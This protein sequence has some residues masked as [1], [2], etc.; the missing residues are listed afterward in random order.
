VFDETIITKWEQESVGLPNSTTK[1]EMTETMFAYC[2]S[3]LQHRAL[4][5][6]NSPNGAIRVFDGDVY[7][8]DT[9]VSDETKLAL[10]KAVRVLED[11]PDSQKDWH[12]DSDGKVLD[13][14]HPSLFPLVY[15]TSKVL[16]IGAPVTTL[17]DCIKKCGE[18]DYANT[19]SPVAGL[20]VWSDKFQWLPCEVDIM[21]GEKP[22]IL[23]YINNLHPERHRELYGLVEDVIHASIPLW[24]KTVIPTNDLW[25]TPQRIEYTSYT[26][27][28]DPE[29]WPEEDQIQR[30]EG[31]DEN[32]FWCRKQEWIEQTRVVE[33]PEPPEEFQPHVLK[34]NPLSFR[35]QFGA[36]PLQ[37]I[38]KLA[39]IE[40]TPEKPEYGGA[41]GTWHVEGKRVRS[42]LSLTSIVYILLEALI[43]ALD[44]HRSTSFFPRTNP[45]APRPSITTPPKTSPHHL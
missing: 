45:S 26:Y 1:T 36:L 8:S 44:A 9:A 28:P 18:G 15:G 17:E 20:E 21:S 30:E 29:T 43:H 33:Q 11:V 22:R 39:N 25:N 12:P 16:P 19:S 7:K 24:E 31:E 5:H 13:L 42:T 35:D 6:P 10:Q 41:R 32:E 37:V 40:L 27:D 3:E 34:R 38:V 4:E 23:T 14:V 2:I